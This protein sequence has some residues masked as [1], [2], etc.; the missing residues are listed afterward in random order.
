MLEDQSGGTTFLGEYFH[1]EARNSSR[2][3]IIWPT[4]V[5]NAM[6]TIS[7]DVAVG[8]A[9]KTISHIHVRWPWLLLPLFM[10]VL[11]SV[12]LVLTVWQSRRWNIPSWRS[13]ALAVME[14]G[15]HR[16]QERLNNRAIMAEVENLSDLGAW[17]QEVKVGLKKTGRYG[18]DI[19]LVDAV[20]GT[21]SG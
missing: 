13:S 19:G 17:A 8:T 16:S 5:S 4:A 21:R 6:R 2:Q 12:L 3:W 18:L 15:V 9:S 20:H 14:H 7:G 11:A 1:K 10:I